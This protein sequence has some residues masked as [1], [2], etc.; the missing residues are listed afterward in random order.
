ISP[1]D[2]GFGSLVIVYRPGGKTYKEL[3]GY[4]KNK[5]A[6]AITQEDFYGRFL[7]HT[8]KYIPDYLYPAVDKLLKGEIKHFPQPIIAAQMLSSIVVNLMKKISLGQKFKGNP[9]TISLDPELSQV[10]K[11]N[12][13]T[14]VNSGSRRVS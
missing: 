11:K 9:Y 7:N 2:M 12:E 5:S 4:A 1:Y 8:M 3:L 6:A 14:L 10:N 13:K